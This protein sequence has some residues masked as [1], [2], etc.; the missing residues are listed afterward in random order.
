[1]AAQLLHGF[2]FA[3]FFAAGFI[4][5]DRLADDDV[6]HSAQTVYTMVMFGL[7]P[8]LAAFVVNGWLIE[9]SGAE[10]TLNRE[11]FA[12]FWLGTACIAAVGSILLLV[13]FRD[14]TAANRPEGRE[15]DE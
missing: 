12:R 7:G 6:R 14:Q 3:C 10:S 2:C 5:V 15:L 8:A 13:G 4:Y 11:Q 9:W 1:M